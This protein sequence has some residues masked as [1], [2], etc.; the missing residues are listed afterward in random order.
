MGP[1]NSL[2]ADCDPDPCSK[3]DP[4]PP[5]VIYGSGSPE[6]GIWIRIPRK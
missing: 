3:H 2:N 6:G 1:A 4:D 5:E